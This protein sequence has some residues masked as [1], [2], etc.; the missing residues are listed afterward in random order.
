LEHIFTYDWY[1]KN[2]VRTPPGIYPTGWEWG[3]TLFWD[4]LW[5]FTEHISATEHDINNRKESCQSTGTPLHDS[6]FGELWPTNGWERLASFCPSPTFSHWETLPALPHGRYITDSRQ[7]WHVLCS[8]T[9]LQSRTTE[10]RARSKLC[11]ASSS[12]L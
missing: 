9:S 4:R 2:L 6:K 3:K 11:H 10:C 1:L 5:T 12:L 7:T 8:G